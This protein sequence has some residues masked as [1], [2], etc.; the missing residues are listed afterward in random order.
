MDKQLMRWSSMGFTH[1]LMFGEWWDIT[2]QFPDR[3]TTIRVD[4]KKKKVVVKHD[5]FN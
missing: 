5:S 1:V 2:D 3:H 4:Y